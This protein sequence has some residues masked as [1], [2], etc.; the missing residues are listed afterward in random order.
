MKKYIIVKKDKWIINENDIREFE[1]SDIPYINE[2]SK[3][4]EYVENAAPTYNPDL[5]WLVETKEIVI[6]DVTKVVQTWTIQSTD[7][8]DAW[9]KIR[10]KRNQLLTESD[11]TQLAD[12]P[13]SGL[14]I[15]DSD[16]N[17]KILWSEYRQRLRNITSDFKSPFDVVFP[18]KPS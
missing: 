2:V 7:T 13:W 1:E 12:V 10:S 17:L 5:Q 11:W 6:T 15:T 16:I 4:C 14:E 18:I 3:W 8:E 9:D